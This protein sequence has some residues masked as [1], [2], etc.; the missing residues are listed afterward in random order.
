VS[1]FI[2]DESDV[3]AVVQLFRLNYDRPWVIKP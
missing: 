3:A 1:Y 2:R